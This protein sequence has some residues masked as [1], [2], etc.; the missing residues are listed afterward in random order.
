MIKILIV[1]DEQKARS[2]LHRLIIEFVPEV[3][4]IRFAA[5]AT[6]A[7]ELLN[8]YE[9]DIA[10]LNIEMAYQNGFQLLISLKNPQSEVIFTTCQSKHAIQ[11]L[12]FSALDYLMKPIDPKEL[13]GAIQRYLVKRNLKPRRPKTYEHFIG[14]A[15]KK[16]SKE[17]RLTVSSSKGVFFF[18]L[19]EI[20]R[21][22]SDRN[23]SVIHFTDQVKP[24]VATKTLKYFEYILEQFKFIRTHK[25]HLV[26][27][28]HVIRISNSN[29]FV[30]LSD[31][32]RIEVSRR[33][34]EVLIRLLNV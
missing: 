2:F 3:S 33:K 15:E 26:N 12:R 23:Y 1:D 13:V 6:K 30:V 19:A 17:F 25:S 9:P 29:D 27:A 7:R 16:D 5:S 22:E 21:I 14:S 31:G 32:T 4:E 28:E 10:F 20:I 34:R 11:A 18:P 8:D 24:F